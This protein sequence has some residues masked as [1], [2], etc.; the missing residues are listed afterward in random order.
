MTLDEIRRKAQEKTICI[1]AGQLAEA[2]HVLL[3]ILAE[4]DLYDVVELLKDYR[5]TGPRRGKR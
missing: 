3:E 4:A 1:T 5:D 2:L